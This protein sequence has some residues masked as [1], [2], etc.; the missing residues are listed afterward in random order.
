MVFTVDDRVSGDVF[1][2][3]AKRIANCIG[4]LRQKAN[5]V[6]DLQ[7]LLLGDGKIM[8]EGLERI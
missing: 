6:R 5:I 8:P 4:H 1:A 7:A 2:A 3:N